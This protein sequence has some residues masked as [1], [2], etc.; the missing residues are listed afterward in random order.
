MSSSAMLAMSAF[1]VAAQGCSTL[2][3]CCHSLM[4]V[5]SN[6]DSTRDSV[7]TSRPSGSSAIQC[8]SSTSLCSP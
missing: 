6:S 2:I 8:R 3:W 1:N 5:M 4:M 7:I